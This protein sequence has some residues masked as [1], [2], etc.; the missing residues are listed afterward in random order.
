MY[1]IH[2]SLSRPPFTDS[3][4]NARVVFTH[5]NTDEEG[6]EGGETKTPKLSFEMKNSNSV[7]K[8]GA[9]RWKKLTTTS[10]QLEEK[11]KND[12]QV[13]LITEDALPSKKKGCCSKKGPSLLLVIGKTF[14]KPLLSSAFFKLLQDLL[15]FVGPQ[16]LK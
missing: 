11:E 15:G 8:R 7:E 10:V 4:C 16:L 13:M 14:W 12:D 2:R 3:L 1:L 6:N 5:H 9:V